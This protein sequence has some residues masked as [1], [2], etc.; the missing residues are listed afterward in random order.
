LI[1][2][3]KEKEKL[4]YSTFTYE[5]YENRFRSKPVYNN[6]NSEGKPDA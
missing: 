5:K 3:G 6:P 1:S 2:F 4:L